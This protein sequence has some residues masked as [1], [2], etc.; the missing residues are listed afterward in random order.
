MSI[1]CLAAVVLLL[2]LLHLQIAPADAGDDAAALLGFKH[3]SVA[4]DQRGVLVGWVNDTSSSSPCTWTG[5]SCADGLRFEEWQDRGKGFLLPKVWVRVTGIEEPLRKFS[6]LWAV[7]TLL[8]S[9]QSVDMETTRK[10][11]FGRVLVAVL[12]PK[13][14]PRTLDVVIGD[15]YFDLVFEVER[16]GFD[17]N[18]DDVEIDWDGGEGEGDGEGKG[19]EKEPEADSETNPADGRTEEREN[20]RLKGGGEKLRDGPRSGQGPADRG[21]GLNEFQDVLHRKADLILDKVVE[22]VL[23]EAASKVLREEEVPVEVTDGDVVGLHE[24]NSGEVEMAMEVTPVVMQRGLT[25]M[26]GT[27]FNKGLGGDSEQGAD[28]GERE[29]SRLST[30]E[31]LA[32]SKLTDAALIP[33]VLRS[34]SRASPRLAGMGAE[35]TLLKAERRMLSRNLESLEGNPS[36]DLYSNPL[37]AQAV[38]NLRALGLGENFNSVSSFE[39]NVQSLLARDL[40]SDRPVTEGGMG[41]VEFSDIESVDSGVFERKALEYLCEDLME[42]VF[43]EDSYHLNGDSKIVQRKRGAKSPRK[44]ASRKLKVKINKVVAS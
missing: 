21:Q 36:T 11:D 23:E 12:D 2:S 34:P 24:K 5:I 28:L 22:E 7:G 38:D 6:I 31:G 13:L 32:E 14:I 40:A 8:G 17:E 35:H 19:E 43:D 26:H 15:H 37:L 42:E 9:T 44:R 27:V 29:S 25:S 33:E 3:A 39:A 30:K 1:G 41:D 16:K 10:S 4:V 20:K 18:G